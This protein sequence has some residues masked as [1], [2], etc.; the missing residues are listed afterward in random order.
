MFEQLTKEIVCFCQN[1]EN[2]HKDCE[3]FVLYELYLRTVSKNY[4]EEIA[5]QR[6]PG[7][8]VV[9]FEE[10]KRLGK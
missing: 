7:D 9:F 6:E 3:E 4:L 10:D 1:P 5:R 8:N 2:S